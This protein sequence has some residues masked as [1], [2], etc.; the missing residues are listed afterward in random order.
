MNE[1]TLQRTFR[2]EV[3]C[4]INVVLIGRDRY[5]IFV[6]YELTGGVESRIV[7]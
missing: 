3:S 5:V 1:N 6:P 7:L 4:K 2:N